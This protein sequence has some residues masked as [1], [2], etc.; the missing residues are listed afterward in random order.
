MS[1]D[2]WLK[3][4]GGWQDE[5]EDW[6]AYE[7]H[8]IAIGLDEA[9]WKRDGLI[10]LSKGWAIGTDAW[11]R[12][13][14][15]EYAEMALSPGLERAEVRDLREATLQRSFDSAMAREGRSSADLETKPLS[16]AWK[17][18]LAERVR[19]ESGASMAWLAHQLKI[20]QPGTL[21]CYLSRRRTG[22]RI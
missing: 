14:A 7:R 15:A 3:A 17:V 16:K 9:R 22:I 13:L 18:E 21:R 6:I 20:G 12:A 10:G 1:P 4:R 11:R 8:L 5:P 19:N 2:A